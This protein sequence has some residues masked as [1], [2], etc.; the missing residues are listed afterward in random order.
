MLSIAENA[1]FCDASRSRFAAAGIDTHEDQRAAA[2]DRYG[3]ARRAD[4]WLMLR[5]IQT[6]IDPRA[7]PM[8]LV[9]RLAARPGRQ[10]GQGYWQ[11]I[12]RI[13][14]PRTTTKAWQAAHMAVSNRA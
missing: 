13:P 7:T 6:A 2:V 1:H 12:D 3:A 5:G 9:G 14:T 11:R 10:V 8:A 4:I